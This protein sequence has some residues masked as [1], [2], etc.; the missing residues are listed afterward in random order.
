MRIAIVNITGGGLS[1]GYKKYLRN[2]VPR[3]AAH[4]E[5]DALLCTA[6]DSVGMRD[7]I[8]AHPKI[9]FVSSKPY[10][11]VSNFILSRPDRELLGTI[12]AFSPDVVFIPADRYLRFGSL[13]VVNMIRNM[14]PFIDNFT[15]DPTMERVKKAIQNI[16]TRRSARHSDRVIAV[17]DF[18]RQT[19]VVTWGIDPSRVERV[20]HGINLPH[21]DEI[22]ERPYSIPD[23]SERDFLFT[24]GSI[25]PARGL[26]DAI[27]ALA[28]SSARGERHRL[29][30]A[31]ATAPSMVAYRAVLEQQ[32]A[33]NGCAQQVTWA[34]NLDEKGMRWCYKNCSLFI[35]TSRIEA[36]PNIA[37][38]AMANGCLIISS[39]TPPM[40]EFF[41]SSALYYTACDSKSLSKVIEDA[42]HLDSAT[43]ASMRDEALKRGSAFSWDRTAAETLAVL[44]KVA[45]AH[46]HRTHLTD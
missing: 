41:G 27:E 33:R 28:H 38:E 4:P 46:T 29:I 15:R 40:P 18:V 25:R 22:V 17:S 12:N 16:D 30:I 19:V 24:C 3:L 31:G 21:V 26:E 8:P 5:V 1:G 45:R 13:P 2:L 20:Y 35:M 9:T 43:K 23:A 34:G 11:L 6:P 42:R 44:T 32:L 36:C 39:D 14:E 37:L 10:R 7:L